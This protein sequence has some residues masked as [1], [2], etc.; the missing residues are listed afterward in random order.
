M[1][2]RLLITMLVASL[3][4]GTLFAGDFSFKFGSLA[5]HPDYLGGVIPTYLNLGA[6]YNGYT[7]LEGNTTE[8]Q[9]YQGAGFTQRVLYQDSTTGAPVAAGTAAQTSNL[10]SADSKIN[11]KQGFLEDDCL[12]A[13]VGIKVAYEKLYETDSSIVSSTVYPDL[14]NATNWYNWLIG[15]VKYDKMVDNIFTQDG[16]SAEFTATYAP[17]ITN[18]TSDFYSAIL[19][20]QYAKTLYTLQSSR[21]GQN[22]LSLVLVDRLF[23]SYTDGDKVPTSYQSKVALGNQ[24]RGFAGYTYNTNFNIVNNLDLRV[25]TFEI[26]EYPVVFLPR[27]NLFVDAGYAAGEYFNSSTTIDSSDKFIM[28]SGLQATLD[29]G[30]MVDLGYQIAYLIQG[31]NLSTSDT[32]NLVSSVTFFLMF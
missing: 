17:S 24:V 20:L 4:T 31:E 11:V 3:V 16:Y 23:T 15:S 22:I 32:G 7:V 8:L 19:D 9:F 25:S 14:A 12:T 29:I 26:T 27:F 5:Q 2:K 21:D 6:G 18:S 10:F 30:D 1:K 28:S 13:N